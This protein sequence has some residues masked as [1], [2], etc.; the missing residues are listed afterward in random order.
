MSVVGLCS[1]QSD[2]GPNWFPER[3]ED[4]APAAAVCGECPSRLAC[5][6]AALKL[7][8][9]LRWGVWAGFWLPA[10][11]AALGAWISSCVTSDVSAR[12]AP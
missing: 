8:R 2:D 12:V 3:S 10:E 5:A 1:S 11:Q 7:P 9:G 6:Q 4:V